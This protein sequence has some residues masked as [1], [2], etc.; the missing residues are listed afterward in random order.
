M[1]WAFAVGLA[2]SGWLLAGRCQRQ[3]LPVG[4]ADG[5][6]RKSKVQN[7][8]EVCGLGHMGRAAALW[9]EDRVLS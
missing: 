1:D 2:R 5:C 4:P 7:G 6:V 3:L 8:F 9:S